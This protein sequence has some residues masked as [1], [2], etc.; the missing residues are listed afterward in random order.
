VYGLPADV[1]ADLV[2]RGL[3]HLGPAQNALFDPLD[4]TNLSA[5]LSRRSVWYFGQRAWAAALDRLRDG[6]TDTYRVDISVRCPFPGHAGACEDDLHLCDTADTGLGG[7]DGARSVGMAAAF[8][9]DRTLTAT[10]SPGLVLAPAEVADT[11]RCLEGSTYHLL[12][13]ALDTDL[14]FFDRT[15]LASCVLA[16]H[17]VVRE[18]GRRGLPARLST[19]LVVLPPFAGLHWWTE[20]LVDG[21]W[22][23]FD[24]LLVRHLERSGV[25]PPGH[26]PELAAISGLLLRFGAR[27][28][29]L[30]THRGLRADVAFAVTRLP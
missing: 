22:A 20:F 6:I 19:G 29:F 28:D 14:G 7:P 16:A 15:S 3:P 1:V 25:L 12:P 30:A 9:G 21:R 24:P 2:C 17:A 10:T 8:V 4:L 26:W 11:L 13:D 5:G 27:V 18:A 23:G